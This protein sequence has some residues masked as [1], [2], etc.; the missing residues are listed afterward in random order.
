MK[1][2]IGIVITLTLMASAGIALAQERGTAAEAKA[3]VKKAAAFA[4]EVGREKALAEFNNPKGKFMQK[5]LFIW[6]VDTNGIGLAHPLTPG[7]VGKPLLGLKDA[8]G[9]AHIKEEV[10]MAKS[11]SS[12][13]IDYRWTN[14]Q[15]KK[16]E[17]KQAYYE[18]VDNMILNC[19]YY[20]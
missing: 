2:L 12:G 19:G 3:M 8:D 7:L 13:I 14:F 18:V 15:T 6:A 11:K 5:D 16:V 17:P 4:K 10:D 1:K 9:K 20:K